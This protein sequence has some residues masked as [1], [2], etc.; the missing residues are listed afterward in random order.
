MEKNKKNELKNNCEQNN[1]IYF[2]FASIFL[3]FTGAINHG[4]FTDIIQ[5]HFVFLAF[6]ILL[7][8]LL[9]LRF[10]DKFYTIVSTKNLLLA[11]TTFL[12]ILFY[13]LDNGIYLISKE[14]IEKINILKFITLSIFLFYFIKISN[15][16][17]I[18]NGFIA[19]IIKNAFTGLLIL[20]L[21]TRIAI[22]SFSPSPLIDV[23]YVTNKAVDNLTNG[24]NPYSAAYTIIAMP[25]VY[26]NPGY[27]PMVTLL[28]TPGK[29]LLGDVRY[30]Y[31]IAQIFTAIIIYLL[32][33]KKYRDDKIMMELPILIFMFLPNSLFVLEQTWIE[34]L[35]LL[36][37]FFF[38]LIFIKQK[39]NYLACIILGIF[40]SLKQNNFPFLILA[41]ANF[42]INF[43]KILTILLAVFLPIMPFLIWNFNSF[44]YAII[45]YPLNYPIMLHSISL[46][47][48]YTIIYKKEMP[49]Y[50]S[51]GI[52]SMLII[53]LIL[54]AK[55]NSL[56]DYLHSSIILMLFL[57]FL[58][59]G[60]ANYYYFISGSLVLLIT[61]CLATKN[62]E[63]INSKIL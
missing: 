58:L 9:N 60:Y 47:S 2:I 51:Y 5:L 11:Y 43:K 16:T 28:N 50:I 35:L 46:N 20:T 53:F 22:I 1:I 36:V 49:F 3:M 34:P 13:F 56:I 48:L 23:F 38:A 12:I 29:L 17:K 6:F 18:N 26:S 37:L 24:I 27:L 7:C 41:L 25:D 42:H 19:Y 4:L 63:T 21:V 62:E 30:G 44:I 15:K 45:S 39:F 59:M 33:R 52:I 40:I 54:R 8:P 10:L 32:L 57:F 14:S 55:K 61:L 31:I